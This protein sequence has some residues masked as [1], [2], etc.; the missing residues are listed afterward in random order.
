MTMT[1]LTD[2]LLYTE[3]V[4]GP[5]FDACSVPMLPFP[6]LSESRVCSAR[7]T[8]VWCLATLYAAAM[9]KR[10]LPSHASS[11]DRSMRLGHFV[12]AW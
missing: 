12:A 6:L 8:S 2:V 10:V 4:R 1:S 11:P 5:S 3:I 7:A 9:G